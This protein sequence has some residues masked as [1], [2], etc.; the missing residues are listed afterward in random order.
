MP[1]LIIAAHFQIAPWEQRYIQ[2][3]L[4][5][6]KHVFVPGRLSPRHLPKI[7][8]I[9]VLSNF[10]NSP[11]DKNIIDGLPKLGLITTRS[12]GFDHIDMAAAKARKITV[13]NVPFYG[14]NTVAEHTLAML[15]TLS[16]RIIECVERTR[17]SN[18]SPK[19]LTGFDLAGKTI[20]IVGLGHIG[21]HVVIM[22]KG[23]GMQVITFDV[24]QD[25]AF[26][27]K[28]GVRFVS[29]NTLLKTS[30]VISLHAPY[31]K[32]TH[33]LINAKNLKL[34]KKGAIL[35]N[36]S[37]GGLVETAALYTALES[38][39]LGGVGLDVLEEENAL[40]ED[41]AHLEHNGK[42]HEL[43]TA[44]ISSRLTD[45]PRAIVTPHNAFNTRE[46]LERILET[47]V[48]N[49]TAWTR[50]KPVNVVVVKK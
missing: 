8:H 34:I 15:L 29:L 37:R 9:N 5:K 48:K 7:K 3:A 40:G 50:G 1:K 20:G 12:T 31:N 14:E 33:H 4:P 22:A 47:T 46:A 23:F 45:H 32:H 24:K 44:L 26:A 6:A 10:I 28:H 25:K 27:K 41:L 2:N 39:R 35:L 43:L 18:F 36:T 30:D 49:M 38:G 13:C 42:N 19:G 16:R 21:K 17:R 11:A